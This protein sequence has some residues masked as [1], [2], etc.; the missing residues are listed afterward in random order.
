MAGYGRIMKEEKNPEIKDS[1][2][3]YLVSLFDDANDFSWDAAKASHAVLLCRMEQGEIKNYMELEKI[4][5]IRRAHAQRHSHPSQSYQ[6]SKR[7]G[8]NNPKSMPC[9]FYNRGNCSQPK[10][11]ETKGI[12]Y[13]H[14]CSACFTNG[15]AFNR[16]ETDCKN[17]LKKVSKNE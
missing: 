10:T 12:L 5:R 16:S 4:D 8:Q 17:K 13:R 6:N 11:H 2:L 15:K 3:D 1:M 7:M 14:I 9:I